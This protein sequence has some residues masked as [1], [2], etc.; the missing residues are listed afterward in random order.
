[1]YKRQP[2]GPCATAAARAALIARVDALMDGAAPRDGMFFQHDAPT[3]AYDDL[4]VGRG[5]I[6]PSRAYRK[7]EGVERDP[8]VRAWI[9]NSLFAR[10]ARATIGAEV[11]LGRAVV[12]TKAAAGATPGGTELPWHQDG[13]NFWGLSAQPTVTLWTALDDAPIASGCVELIPGS[14]HGGLA[15]PAGGTIPAA[16]TDARPAV[17][18]PAAAGDV[19]LLH[20]LV[21][22]RSRRNHTAQPRRALSIVLMPASTRC[23][24]TRRA[25][26]Q[27]VRLYG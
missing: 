7:I 15:T 12:W 22:H 9:E 6:G 25:P 17:T 26:R 10:V 3:G 5:W 23:T 21:W 8:V 14:H 13:G 18:V 2:L 24:R 16:L 11:V 20:N 27:F 4:P 1:M 19:V